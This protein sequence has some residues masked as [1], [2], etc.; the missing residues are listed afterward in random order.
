MKSLH[1]CVGGA[2]KWTCV[3]ADVCTY[4]IMEPGK[5]LK[6]CDEIGSFLRQKLPV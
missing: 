2:C 6:I 4:N 1:V 5:Q 3:C